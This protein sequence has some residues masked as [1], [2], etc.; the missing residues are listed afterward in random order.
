MMRDSNLAMTLARMAR[1]L[2]ADKRVRREHLRWVK[3][4]RRL[5]WR[6]AARQGLS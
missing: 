1:E 5:I 6:A 4:Q 3:R 2:E